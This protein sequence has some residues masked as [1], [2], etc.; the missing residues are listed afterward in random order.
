LLH[1]LAVNE[2]ARPV[3]SDAEEGPD[4]VTV[5]GKNVGVEIEDAQALKAHKD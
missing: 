3:V 5:I 4:E 1:Q 2:L